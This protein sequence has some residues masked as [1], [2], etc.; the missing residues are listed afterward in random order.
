MEI[1]I[2]EV[3]D[4][5]RRD[6]RQDGLLE[7]L[8]HSTGLEDANGDEPSVLCRV[9]LFRSAEITL[10]SWFWCLRC[11]LDHLLIGS[12]LTGTADPCLFN[13]FECRIEV[14]AMVV[15]SF[16]NV[17]L[18]RLPSALALY[19]V[20]FDSL[21]VR[22]VLL[23]I[24][25]ALFGASIRVQFQERLDYTGNLPLTGVTV[26]PVFGKIPINEMV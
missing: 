12:S 8:S 1:S 26:V 4:R 20:Y 23:G 24:Q 6:V 9:T 5:F 11:L 2:S 13:P 19:S 16:W 14:I 15:V 25:S 17:V 21:F 22:D 18:P 7:M 10:L 3:G